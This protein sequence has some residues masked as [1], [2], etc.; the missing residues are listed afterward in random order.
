MDMYAGQLRGPVASGELLATFQKHDAQGTGRV[1]LEGLRA[2][3]EA[4]K[5]T[6]KHGGQAEQAL[7][8]VMRYMG[9]DGQ[10]EYARFIDYIVEP[11]DY[12]LYASA[13]ET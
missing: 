8:T 5:L 2:V 12:K 13:T 1:S 6:P 10:L 4:Y 7:L 9:K 11:E 3:L